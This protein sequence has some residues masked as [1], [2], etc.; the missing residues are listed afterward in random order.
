MIKRILIGVGLMSLGAAGFYLVQQWVSPMPSHTTEAS[1]TP[2]ESPVVEPAADRQLTLSADAITRAGIQTVVVES[3]S[4]P[5]IRRVPAVVEPHGYRVVD[6]T[7]LVSGTVIEV[8]AE[9]GQ[10]VR[11]GA[12]VARLRSPEL[13]D[14]V[15]RW[16]TLRAE[17][18]VA[19]QRLART[20]SLAKIG[21]ASRQDLEEDQAGLVRVRTELDTSQARL[22]RLGVPEARLLSMQS[23]DGL[24]EMFDVFAQAGG[25]VTAR[26]VNPGQNVDATQPIVTLADRSAVWVIGD[27][28]EADLAQV[29]VGQQARVTSEA[30][31]GREWS[32]RV[33]YL[34]PAIARATRTVKIRI[35]VANPDEALR[36]GMFVSAALDVRGDATEVTVPTT[37]VQSLG[38]VDV[39]YVEVAPGRFEERPVA[40]V[41]AGDRVV[42]SGSFALRSERDR[43]GWPQPEAPSLS[44]SVPQPTPAVPAPV[45][46]RV[47][48]VTAAGL[49]PSRVV[50]PANQAVDLVFVR[51]VEVTCGTEV[52]I[53]DLKIRRDLPLNERIT[54]RLPPQPPGEL[55]FSCGMDMLRG[56]IVVGRSSG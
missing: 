6:V 39:V 1:S 10:V 42:T 11:Q 8:R 4:G 27:V 26:M 24:P 19:A 32:G 33:T 40:G 46:T 48:E 29:R 28:F 9:L 2:M 3:G 20:E 17:R 13:T 41:R 52:D 18:D 56:V 5:G 31:P 54:I 30:F 50:V 44:P 43:L 23:G 14:E 53:P 7:P 55:S 15:R 21:A 51:R 12:V 38:A 34:D 16:L 37:A 25:V 22:A 47:V 36:F 35:E 49:I 45:I